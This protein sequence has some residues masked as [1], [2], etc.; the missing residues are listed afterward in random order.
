LEDGVI[1]ILNGKTEDAAVL[2]M[3]IISQM[4]T[5]R[6]KD[7]CETCKWSVTVGIYLREYREA[8]NVHR[9]A[10]ANSLL[11]PISKIPSQK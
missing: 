10:Q 9:V 2:W 6:I 4:Q 8:E 7:F 11:D 1:I 3:D 5:H